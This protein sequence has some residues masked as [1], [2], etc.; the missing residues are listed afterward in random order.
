MHGTKHPKQW[1]FLL[2]RSCV[3][4]QNPFVMDVSLLGGLPTHTTKFEPLNS[5]DSTVQESFFSG[6]FLVPKHISAPSPPPP[7]NQKKQL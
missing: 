7:K 1:T 2:I 3:G 5:N 4:Y 6:G